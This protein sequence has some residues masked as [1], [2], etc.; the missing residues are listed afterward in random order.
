MASWKLEVE[1][2]WLDLEVDVFLKEIGVDFEESFLSPL[3]ASTLEHNPYSGH[4]WVFFRLQ[5]LLPGVLHAAPISKVG[6]SPALWEEWF[7]EGTENHH[8]S[9][10]NHKSLVIPPRAGEPVLHWRSPLND[11]E[12]PETVMDVDWHYFNDADQR[13][14]LLR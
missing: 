2:V 11:I 4:T 14:F 5:R 12:H 1:K 9:M 6:P 8:H 10:R 13:P 7:I 3:R